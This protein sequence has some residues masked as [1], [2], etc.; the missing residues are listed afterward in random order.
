MVGVNLDGNAQVQFLKD[1]L[2]PYV[3]ECDFSE[4]PPE[5]EYE[6]HLGNNAFEA[7]D[8]E[9][10]H[11]IIRH[12]KPKRIVE[13]GSGY[14]TRVSARAA[15]MNQHEGRPT[16]L[17]CIEPYPSQTLRN[18]FPGL[19]SLLISDVQ[20][21][22]PA[23]FRT[24]EKDDILFI[25]STHVAK[26]G[27]D[28]VYEYLELLPRLQPGVIVHIHDIFMPFEYP[29]EWILRDQ[30][31]WTEQYLLQAFLAFN[32]TFDVLWGGSFM[33]QNYKGLLEEVFPTWR[34]SYTR[35]PAEIRK[36]AVT[37]DG[38]NVWPASFWI[39]RMA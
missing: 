7:L 27:S 34:G 20:D 26:I 14:S 12:F 32:T 25:D 35:L 23:I 30:F 11:C 22:D 10:L 16:N 13:I 37:A 5:F 4:A 19:S 24:L 28:V 31:F 6:F 33:S 36:L 1:V 38:Q 9:V 18:G 21:V 3:K 15:L 17:T 2:L 29:R 8:A 39:R